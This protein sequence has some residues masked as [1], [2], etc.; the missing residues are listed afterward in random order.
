MKKV[1]LILIF[2][3]TN[4]ICSGQEKPKIDMQDWMKRGLNVIF[5]NN[6]TKDKKYNC[7]YKNDEL[8]VNCESNIN[9]PYNDLMENEVEIRNLSKEMTYRTVDIFKD[10]ISENYETI[11]NSRYINIVFTILTSD[12][13]NIS[14]T[15][16]LNVNDLQ[17]IIPYYNKK[18]FFEILK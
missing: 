18:D 7:Y 2:I 3:L 4:G 14:Y 17:K 8:Y 11:F 13:K 6:S 10:A 9:V 5:E 1:V 12:Y 15:Y 16:F